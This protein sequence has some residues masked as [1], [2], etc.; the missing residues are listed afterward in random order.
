VTISGEIG[1][2]ERNEEFLAI[3]SQPCPK[4]SGLLRRIFASFFQENDELIK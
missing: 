2:E 1:R 3:V 4:D